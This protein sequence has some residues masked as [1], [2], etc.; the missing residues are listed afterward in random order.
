MKHITIDLWRSKTAEGLDKIRNEV[1]QQILNHDNTIDIGEAIIN[2]TQKE[3]CLPQG[4]VGK[5]V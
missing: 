4:T 1:Y 5:I 3:K 2:G